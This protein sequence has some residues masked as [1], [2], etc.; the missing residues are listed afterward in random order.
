[1]KLSKNN[2]I[3]IDQKPFLFIKEEKDIKALLADFYEDVCFVEEEPSKS[4]DV[5]FL[6]NFIDWLTKNNYVKSPDDN[7]T[8]FDKVIEVQTTSL[9]TPFQV[10]FTTVNDVEKASSIFDNPE[11]LTVTIALDYAHESPVFANTKVYL[12]SASTFKL[13]S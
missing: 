6:H 13:R 1:M 2:L 5:V 12:W 10:I 9:F 7:H 11:T 8:T 3:I 4:I